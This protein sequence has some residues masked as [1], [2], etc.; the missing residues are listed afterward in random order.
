[1]ALP[2]LLPHDGPVS[3]DA[4]PKVMAERVGFEPTIPVK[5]CPLSRRI[6]STTHAPLRIKTS[7]ALRLRFLGRFLRSFASLRISPAGSRSPPRHAK[8]ARAGEPRCAHAR[9]PAQFQPLTHLSALKLCW[10]EGY[11]RRPLKK[12]CS[13]PAHS[14]ASTPPRTSMT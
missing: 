4:V 9:K 14:P 2:K 1:M 11:C 8:S 12:S 13:R 3:V 5:V 6:V 7:H 10:L